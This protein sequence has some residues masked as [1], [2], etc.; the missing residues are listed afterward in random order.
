M[1]RPHFA[2]FALFYTGLSGFCS[3][4]PSKAAVGGRGGCGSLRDKW[5]LTSDLSYILL[6]LTS[7]DFL[8]YLRINLISVRPG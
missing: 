3:I 1:D 6:N 7:K 8:Y 4:C 2:F 5:A